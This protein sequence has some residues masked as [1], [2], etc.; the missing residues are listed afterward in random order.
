[1]STLPDYFILSNLLL[2]TRPKQNTRVTAPKEN[3][4]KLRDGK[5]C[6]DKTRLYETML[7][8]FVCHRFDGRLALTKFAFS[9]VLLIVHLL[10]Q[11]FAEKEVDRLYALL[12]SL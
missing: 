6:I 8:S 9:Y 1:M 12:I 3:S 4:P 2:P 11:G 10:I 7:M 5:G